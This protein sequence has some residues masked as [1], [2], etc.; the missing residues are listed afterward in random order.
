M[1]DLPPPLPPDKGKPGSKD[2]SQLWP[3]GWILPQLKS[4]VRNIV[5]ASIS[6]LQCCRTS[7]RQALLCLLTIMYLSQTAWAKASDS[8]TPG[9]PYLHTLASAETVG[10]IFVAKDT[11]SIDYEVPISQ[12]E[13]TIDLLSLKV[14]SMQYSS[15]LEKLQPLTLKSGD[16]TYTV[17][18]AALPLHMASTVCNNFKLSPMSIKDIPRNF[19]VPFSVFSIVYHL[20]IL[21]SNSRLTCLY[22]TKVVP[23]QECL[24][25]IQLATQGDPSFPVQQQLKDFIVKNATA[26]TVYI[27]QDLD[28]F[29]ISSTPYGI[30]ACV[31]EISVTTSDGLKRLHQHFFAKLVD[32]FGH[33]FDVIEL[34]AYRLGD[35]ILTIVT[36]ESASYLLP[37]DISEIEEGI[38][39]LI[40][41]LLPNIAN[42]K[43]DESDFDLF[44]SK[45]VNKSQDLQL[46]ELKNSLEDIKRL[47][48]RKKAILFTSL[49]QFNLSVQKRLTALAKAITNS[50]SGKDMFPNTVLFSP[51]QSPYSFKSFVLNSLRI[52]DEE[53]LIQFFLIIQNQKNILYQ[54]IADV[55]NI[56]FSPAHLTRA[57]FSALVRD[58][59]MSIGRVVAVTNIKNSTK[60]SPLKIK[61]ET[62]IPARTRTYPDPWNQ[63]GTKIP[64]KTRTKR[65]WGTFWG[66]TF[67][68]AT[69]EDM[70]KVLE[71]ELSMGD[72][73]LK[74]SKSLWN[75]TITNSQLINSLKA[76]T[77]GVDKLVHEEQTIFSQIDSLF[78]S[79]EKQLEQLNDLISMVDKT[80]T[81][82]SDY[83]MIQLQISLLIHL[84][85]KVKALVSAILTHTV[86]VTQIPL[87][88]FKPHLQDNLKITLRLANYKLKQTDKGTVLNVQIPV[89]SNP[90]FMYTFNV[91]PVKMNDTWYQAITP[92]DIA[93]NAVNDIIDTQDTIKKCTRVHDDYACY[94][95]HVRIYKLS[96]LVAADQG[97]T[98]P[99]LRS[100]PLCAAQTL[101]MILNPSNNKDMPCG[102]E[103]FHVLKQQKYVQMGRKLLLASPISD[104]LKSECKRKTDDANQPVKIGLNT[105]LIKKD[106]HY[107]TS[108]LVI[109]SVNSIEK[110]DEITDFAEIDTVNAISSLDSLL[111]QSIPSVGNMSLI[112]QKLQKYNDSLTENKNTVEN[113][114]KTLASI[115]QLNQITQFDP[116][117]LNFNQ[118][119]ATSNWVTFIFW[120]LVL[121]VTGIIAYGSYKKCPSKCTNCMVIPL[122]VLKHM[123]CVCVNVVRQAAAVSYQATAQEDLEMNQ[124]SHSGQNNHSI[125]SQPIRNANSASA[126]SANPNSATNTDA[127]ALANYSQKEINFFRLNPVPL[128]WSVLT[129]AYEAL[130]IQAVIA[131]S[132]S[133]YK[134]I[135]Y[136]TISKVVTD[137]EN[138]VLE[139]IPLPPANILERY[140]AILKVALPI[141]TFTDD[142]GIIRHK[143]Y[144]FLTYN[145]VSNSWIDSHTGHII[146]GLA[147]PAEYITAN[148]Y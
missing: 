58:K 62:K 31:G 97:N 134:R 122:L 96:G 8:Y 32:V 78:E 144:M 135:K 133:E 55:L 148:R 22:P 59:P 53:I 85:D 91:L 26:S 100:K 125:S 102:M 40:P 19:K 106:C 51:N 35:A 64:S 119:L 21:S 1:A 29:R 142:E 131:L 25:D 65:S 39:G 47:P 92:I 132:D 75:I 105:L 10:K 6:Q 80:T 20:E 86:D 48:D 7:R 44:F 99:S 130:A 24:D 111:E 11:L 3:K 17:F 12:I 68:L 63:D 101:H 76:V 33:I 136:N 41:D 23:E 49:V 46:H 84:T 81:L 18:Q 108:Q 127:N 137:L 57:M 27:V 121:L 52:S 9:Y 90:F 104:T 123:C 82:I 36:E 61:T 30:S 73:E 15:D 103:I 69:Q 128:Q 87:S 124:N 43:S 112:R 74:L 71:H 129:A 110:I 147:S 109:H 83:Q 66:S 118:P 38:V 140:Q 139:Y 141:P 77:A 14:S 70:T 126:I 79:E 95:K 115:E 94:P 28:K 42:A 45:V 5:V 67:A 98:L 145:P 72:N 4:C 146:T 138:M 2:P 117:T 89:L 120:T 88:I 56:P 54:N 107:E 34:N 37:A 50:T 143:K 113:L 60:S 116:T 93:V 13:E 114:S 16:F